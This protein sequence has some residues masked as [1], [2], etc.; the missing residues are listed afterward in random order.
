[1]PMLLD[2]QVKLL[3][4]VEVLEPLSQEELS[5]LGRHSPD[6]FLD[7]GETF[8]KPQ[9]ETERLFVLKR[10]RMQIYEIDPDNGEEITLSIV[11]GG[12]IFG[13]MVLTG[14]RL[15]GVYVR[16]LEPSVVCSLKRRD[17]E[18]IIL[19]HPEVGLRLVRR[20]SEELREA[21]IRLAD[22]SRKD[23][24][25]RLASLILRL[26][27]KEG[28]IT[29]EGIKIPTRYTHE[30]LGTMIG[31]KRVAVTRAFN[32]LRQAGAVR[33]HR[34]YVNITDKEALER[35]ASTKR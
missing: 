33:L 20:L 10:G 25:A 26:I 11:E 23:V 9:E 14:Q 28:V 35:I 2:E 30:R 29:K 6:S 27:D 12:N 13:Q 22:L 19:S 8:H 34:R 7:E 3:S 15:S 4:M 5:Q 17:L 31:A 16:A 32:Q 24:Q 21:E 18:H 1:M